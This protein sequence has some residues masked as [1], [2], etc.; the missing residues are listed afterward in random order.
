MRQLL[1]AASAT[2]LIAF[3]APAIAATE[4]AA[5]LTQD[6][7]VADAA[8]VAPK[9]QAAEREALVEAHSPADDVAQSA[10]AGGEDMSLEFIFYAGL[11]VLI[12]VSL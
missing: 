3:S 6:E 4:P 2:F 5:A 10:T 7:T 1:L 12:L 11:I 8:F 9:P